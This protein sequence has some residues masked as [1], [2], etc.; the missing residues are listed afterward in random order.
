MIIKEKKKTQ[1]SRENRK[2]KNYL[3][4]AGAIGYNFGTG[5]NN[6]EFGYHYKPNKI[7]GLQYQEFRNSTPFFSSTRE[8]DIS[9][10]ERNRKGHALI[11]SYKSM[12]QNSFY[13][14]TSLYH[15][16]QERVKESDSISTSENEEFQKV[17]YEDTGLLFTLGNQWQWENF[18]LG[19][20]WIGMSTVLAILNQEGDY[21]VDNR[22]LAEYTLLS[23]Y[24][25]YAF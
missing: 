23:F 8:E 17:R 18:T 2:D 6:F 1:E 12:L 16:V 24:I 13:I 9:D 4:T 25:G 10:Y 14:K 11:L 19:C 22:E 5:T 7:I 3:I 21:K 15:R 20:D